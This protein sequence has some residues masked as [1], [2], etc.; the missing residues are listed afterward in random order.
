MGSGRCL[1]LEHQWARSLL[2]ITQF[3]LMRL[4]HV[5]KPSHH[6]TELCMTSGELP[7]ERNHMQ[8]PFGRLRAPERA[9]ISWTF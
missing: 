6:A 4:E 9:D 7:Q 5:T 3:D 2:E 1:V 8:Q